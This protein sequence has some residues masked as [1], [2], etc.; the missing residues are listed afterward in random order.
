MSSFIFKHCIHEYCSEHKNNLL[1]ELKE[2]AKEIKIIFLIKC[3]KLRFSIRDMC[4]S[5]LMSF[6]QHKWVFKIFLSIR[7]WLKISNKML[8]VFWEIDFYLWSKAMREEIARCSSNLYSCRGLTLCCWILILH[9]KKLFTIHRFFDYKAKFPSSCI[10]CD[11][12]WLR[13]LSQWIFTQLAF[14]GWEVKDEN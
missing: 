9:I 8:K 12:S 13:G 3:N 5:N 1:E 2:S 7:K 10:P 6:T 14:N 11:S 4:H